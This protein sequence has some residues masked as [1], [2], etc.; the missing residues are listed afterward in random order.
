MEI[1][2]TYRRKQDRSEI[3]ILLESLNKNKRCDKTRYVQQSPLFAPVQKSG[4]PVTFELSQQ[5]KN[6][7]VD[8]YIDKTLEKGEPLEGVS[9]EQFSEYYYRKH[10]NNLFGEDLDNEYRNAV[11]GYNNIAAEAQW[12]YDDNFKIPSQILYSDEVEAYRQAAFEKYVRGEE[13]KPWEMHIITMDKEVMEH[14][15]Y[16]RQ[17][18]RQR[19]IL[20]RKIDELLSDNGIE[21]EPDTELNFETWAKEIIVTGTGDDALDKQITELLTDTKFKMESNSIP[22][23]FGFALERQYFYNHKDIIDEIGETRHFLAAAER[24]L[25]E[26]GGEVSIF[27]LSLDEDRNVI[28]L[29]EKYD[30]YIKDY[31]IGEYLDCFLPVELAPIKDDV[32]KARE[33]R[34]FFRSAVDSIA[35]GNYEKLKSIKG[36]LIYKNGELHSK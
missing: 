3:E 27:D 14:G 36:E 20:G 22:S 31:A 24:Y 6:E 35:N 29:P 19:V 21:L 23:H 28:G 13:M 9:K 15:M 26:D 5:A 16:D 7:L 2:N 33:M 32:F 25:K 11:K 30:K 12:R 4:D 18:E 17:M 8:A 1:H 34:E 10:G